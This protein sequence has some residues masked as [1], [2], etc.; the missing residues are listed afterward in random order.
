VANQRPFPTGYG[1]FHSGI[2]TVAERRPASV[3]FIMLRYCLLFSS[4]AALLTGFAARADIYRWTDKNGDVVYSNVAPSGE[5]TA[6]N[7]TLVTRSSPYVAPPGPTNQELVARIQSLE[8]Q[9]QAQSAAPPIM[10]AGPAYPPQP[11]A[12]A[13]PAPMPAV[14]YYDNGLAGAYDSTYLSP[15]VSPLLPLTVVSVTPLR[16]R[17]PFVRRGIGRDWNHGGF[18]SRGGTHGFPGRSPGGGVPRPR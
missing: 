11:I 15:F 12:Y 4:L 3:C 5:Q 16:G 14:T 18:G 9:L 6:K 7:V 17:S 1:L 2:A 13:Q 10:V 8:Q